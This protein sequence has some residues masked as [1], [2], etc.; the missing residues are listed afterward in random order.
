MET[1]TKYGKL[2]LMP[3]TE[4]KQGKAI[5]YKWQCD[6]GKVVRKTM[7]QVKGKGLKSCGCG[8]I[9][10]K[11][12]DWEFGKKLLT[13]GNTPIQVAA[14]LKCSITTLRKELG[15]HINKLQ[16]ELEP[17]QEEDAKHK[18]CKRTGASIPDVIKSHLKQYG[19]RLQRQLVDE[20]IN[21]PLERPLFFDTL[22]QLAARKEIIRWAN[23][24]VRV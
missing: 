12:Y 21:S 10:M 22:N 1:K 7:Y 23:D 11:G 19:P 5:N 17:C 13:E 15:A 3:G 16:K 2:T 6:C 18:K 4:L 8:R 9:T 20:L 24:W 14:R